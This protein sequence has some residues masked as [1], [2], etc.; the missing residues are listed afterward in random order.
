[1]QPVMP[2]F[3]QEQEEQGYKKEESPPQ[4]EALTFAGDGTVVRGMM[5]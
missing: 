4:E 3:A 1:M 5:L 2:T